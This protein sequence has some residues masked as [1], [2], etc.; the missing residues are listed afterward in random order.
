MMSMTTHL[1]TKFHTALMMS[2]TTFADGGSRNTH[3]RI[4]LTVDIALHCVILS[5]LTSLMTIKIA[6][7]YVIMS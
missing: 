7:R 2:I 3:N 1:V 6:Q 4:L 5:I